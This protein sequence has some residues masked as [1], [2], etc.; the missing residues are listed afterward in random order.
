M[1]GKKRKEQRKEQWEEKTEEQEE[2]T[3]E[4]ILEEGENKKDK[5]EK[6]AEN[7]V[8]AEPAEILEEKA[9]DIEAQ[10][11]VDLDREEKNWEQEK[12]ELF[13]QIK[14]KQAEMDNL[15][16]INK[17]EQA[18]AREYALYDF[19]CKL[20]PVLDSLERAVESAR[21]DEDVPDAHV[22]GLE[23]IYKLLF[24]ILDQEGVSVIEATGTPFDP[25]CHH[26]VMEVDSEE[27]EPGHVV[28][29]LQKGY[30]HRERILRPAMVK[31]CRE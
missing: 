18:E 26:A 25:H 3:A 7:V 21:A 1:A 31:V 28:E 2:Q 24:Q 22:D 15:R 4:D 16:R 6:E 19:L 12:E 10:S 13:D 9:D 14:R 17:K 29:E 23:M 27:D 30:R 8:Q 11:E 20:L 5:R